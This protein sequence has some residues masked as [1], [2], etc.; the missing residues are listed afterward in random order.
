[1]YFDIPESLQPMIKEMRMSHYSIFPTNARA[2]EHLLLTIGNGY[3]WE[4]GELVCI[5]ATDESDVVFTKSML[6]AMGWKYLQ[7]DD[8]PLHSIYPVCE[9]Y[10]KLFNW[11]EDIKDD[12]KELIINFCR[13][14]ID[15]TNSDMKLFIKARAAFLYTAVNPSRKQ[16]VNKEY[17]NFLVLKKAIKELAK[18]KGFQLKFYKTKKKQVRIGTMI[19]EILDEIKSEEG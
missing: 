11:P 18:E 14:L 5:D 9:E 1:M 19:D 8:I 10:A 7:Y 3:E 6:T 13:M 4:N 17:T 16:L 2:V 15:V 12:W